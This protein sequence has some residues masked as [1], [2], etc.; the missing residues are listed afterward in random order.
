MH[1]RVHGRTG[2]TDGRFRV[3][4][5]PDSRR[6]PPVDMCESTAELAT[7]GRVQHEVDGGVN[8]DEQVADAVQYHLAF[9]LLCQGLRRVHAVQYHFAVGFLCQALRRV[10]DGLRQLTHEED[11]DDD[12]EHRRDARLLRCAARATR[13]CPRDGHQGGALT[14]RAHHVAHEQRVEYQ[15]QRHR[16]VGEENLYDI[17]VPEFKRRIIADRRPEVGGERN[18]RAGDT[19]GRDDV[20]GSFRRTHDATPH[21]VTHANVALNRERQR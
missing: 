9:G 14:L 1:G 10:H 5:D 8:D 16:Q 20:Y 18:Q 11:D 12:D 6:E 4:N 19:H 15:E 3:G 21:R 2:R 7:D 17:Q 13:G